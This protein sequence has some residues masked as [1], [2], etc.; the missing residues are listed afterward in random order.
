MLIAS[1]STAH[2]QFYPGNLAVLR[3]GDGVETLSDSGN[4]VSIDQY[5]T[6]GGFIN[7]AAIP[8]N[9]AQS[10]VIS[11]KASSEGFINLSADKHFLTL[12]GYNTSLGSTNS[13]PGSSSSIVD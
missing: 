12:V 1:G 8:T 10:L 9:G 4:L 3:V 7:S 2:A 11:G 6:V 13:L 5:T